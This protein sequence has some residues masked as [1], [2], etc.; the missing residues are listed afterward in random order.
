M[1][2]RITYLRASM[3]LIEMGGAAIL[4]DPWYRRHLRGLP[5]YYSPPMS[6]ASL[7]PVDLVLVSHLHPDHF[8][9]RALRSIAS[10]RTALAG[11]PG[12]RRRA[13]GIRC[14]DVIEMS[15]WEERRFGPIRVRATE[16]RH[17][18]YECNYFLSEH[19][20]RSGGGISV[21]FGGDSRFSTAF[22]AMAA[23][24]L[25]SDVALLPVGG[26]RVLGRRIVMDPADACRAAEIL[27]ARF[28]IPI[29]EGGTWMS[30]PPLS[31]HPGRGRDLQHIAESRGARFDV[32]LLDPGGSAIF[33]LESG[34]VAVAR[35]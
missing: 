3:L 35:D 22:G 13:T 26:T 4:T 30:V 32:I 19:E 33:T 11:P 24:G 1:S 28:V 10:E 29:H 18:G 25:R 15:W 21:F 2:V 34:R 14:A 8:D 5:C 12:T 17:S 20:P 7:P 6:I 31:L 23:K 16:S 9:T 27:G